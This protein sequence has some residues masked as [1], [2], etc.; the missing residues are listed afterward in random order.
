MLWWDF[1]RTRQNLQSQ[2]NQVT[3]Y[4][5]FTKE[6]EKENRFHCV[7][8][9]CQT[10]TSHGPSTKKSGWQNAS[11]WVA[12][13]EGNQSC[14]SSLLNI[15]ARQKWCSSV[16]LI[17]SYGDNSCAVHRGSKEPTHDCQVQHLTA[18]SQLLVGHWDSW[19][20]AL[21]RAGTSSP[22]FK[23]RNGALFS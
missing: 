15:S 2:L 7:E 4:L 3:H 12:L 8:K 16:L 20:T 23:T 21:L 14:S 5:T 22:C 10:V 19:R 1:H 11:S 17:R 6:H 13:L 18:S 9:P